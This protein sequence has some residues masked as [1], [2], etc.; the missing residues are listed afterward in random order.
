LSD[1]QEQDRISKVG[2]TV[3]GLCTPIMGIDANKRLELF[4]F[5]NDETRGKDRMKLQCP[6]KYCDGASALL[7]FQVGRDKFPSKRQLKLEC[8]EFPWKSSEQGGDYMD[9]IGPNLRTSTCVPQYQ[10]KWQGQ[11]FSKLPPFPA[12]IAEEEKLFSFLFRYMDDDVQSVS[13]VQQKYLAG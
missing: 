5:S 8:D 10:N 11:C 7:N 13:N 9:Q 12:T 2:V 3:T 6:S 1:I 4:T